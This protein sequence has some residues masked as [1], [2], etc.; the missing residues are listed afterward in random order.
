MGVYQQKA[1]E[2]GSCSFYKAGYFS[3]CSV[4]TGIQTQALKTVKEWTGQ[5]EQAGREVSFFCVLYTGCPQKVWFRLK[6]DLPTSKMQIKSK[7]SHFK[8]FN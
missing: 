8:G 3:W 1:Q 7:P 4:Y 6:V 5:Q 2:L